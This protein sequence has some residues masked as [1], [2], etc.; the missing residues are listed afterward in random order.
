MEALITSTITVAIAEIGDKTQFLSLLLAAKFRNKL[1]IILGI[2]VATLSNHA[3]SAAFGVWLS[4]FLIGSW[5][6]WIIGGSFILVGLWLLAPE[7]DEATNNQF[8][9]YGA[10]IVSAL[11][12]FIT[13][14]GDKTQVATVLLGAQ[15]QSTLIVTLGTTLG[16]LITNVPV[17]YAGQKLM[18]Q[19][20]LN[21]TRMVAAFIFI[22]VGLLSIFVNK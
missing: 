1:A 5:G 22:C 20:P 11:L 14:I 9:R 6:G 8:D 4:D 15:F 2:L 18:S 17:I 7:K 19:I 13:E 12:F 10:F 3:V 16:M 21:F